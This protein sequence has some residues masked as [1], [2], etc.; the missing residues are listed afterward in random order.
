MPE[1]VLPES[2]CGRVYHLW[3]VEIENMYYS[4][5]SPLNKLWM[6]LGLLLGMIMSPIVMGI[7]F[8][9]LFT[10]ISL[11]MRLL[12]RDELKLKP[13][14]CQSS[15]RLVEHSRPDLQS[16]KNQFWAN[17]EIMEV[18]KELWQFLRARKKLWLAPLIIIMFLVGG[19]LIL[20][21]GSVVA[22]FVYTMF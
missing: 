8:F 9:G 4:F 20:A 22:P 6:R 13:K 16:F 19:L 15:W 1:M 14:P 2:S 10:P 18:L 3:K 5:L 7:I 11:V 17:G 21:E 12:G